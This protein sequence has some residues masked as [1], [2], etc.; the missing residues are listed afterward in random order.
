[1]TVTPKIER[2]RYGAKAAAA[3]SGVLPTPFPRTIGPN[4]LMY[5]QEVVDSGLT[6]D[7]TDRFEQAF[8]RAMGVA[9]CIATSGCTPSLHA[10]VLASAWEPGDE[11]IVS[12]ITDYG[13]VQ[14]LIAQGIIPVFPD[15]EPG[16]INF[17]A[18]TIQPHLTDRTRAI[19]CVH[20]TGLMVDMDP[21]LELAARRGIPVY[22]DVCQAIF[23]VY[24]G[25]T[26]GTLG[27]A[28]AF[29][30]DPEKT[31]GSD[32]GG[33]V[34]TNDDALAERIRFV[35]QARG[36]QM[37]PGFGRVHTVA[38]YAYRMPQCTAAICLA[39][40]EIIREQVAHID[41]MI[42]LQTD[43]L[44]QIP[45]IRPLAIPEYQDVYSCWMAGI[46][47]EPEAFNCSAGEFAAQLAEAGLPGAGLG[48]YY[49]MPAALEC[50]RERADEQR[51]PYSMPP[52]SR[53][54]SYRGE[55]LPNA[56]GFLE[57]FI[58]WSTFCAKY[59]PDDCRRAA[60]IVREVA[61]RNRR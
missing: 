12:P 41:A 46:S 21:L 14:G 32:V 15:T 56:W 29:S 25:R 59:Q 33:C 55:D 51:Y 42:R 53:R 23:S 8:A 4:A 2:A 3:D 22:E 35:G 13:T 24:K 17:S 28:A 49:L 19:F 7:M 16:S 36:G 47:L 39:Q 52:A 27:H 31:M 40:L 11:V 6:V 26:A 20:K 10:L 45:G 44:R 60:E 50:L 61:E 1:M 58:R 54:F 48:K 57:T 30:F 18:R 5:L 38:G 43:L 34:I 9:H 37:R